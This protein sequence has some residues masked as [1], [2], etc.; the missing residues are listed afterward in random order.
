MPV[1]VSNPAH[2]RSAASPR[3]AVDPA[4]ATVFVPTTNGKLVANPTMDES[5][6]PE[7]SPC[8]AYE[9]AATTITIFRPLPIVGRIAARPATVFFATS[10]AAA[11]EASE[12]PAFA[13][14]PFAV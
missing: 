1:A 8:P 14:L 10:P 9:P 5:A 3:N 6:S 2:W 4:D 12:N 7:R 11:L 13:S